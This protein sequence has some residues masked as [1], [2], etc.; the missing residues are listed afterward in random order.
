V[1]AA[2]NWDDSVGYL[3][4][5]RYHLVE[6]METNS[7]SCQNQTERVR[8]RIN[9]EWGRTSRVS[10]SA[11]V[12]PAGLT[13]FRVGSGKDPGYGEGVARWAWWVA[14]WAA[15]KQREGEWK[16]G[17]GWVGLGDQPGFGPLPNRS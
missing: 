15:R 3:K 11:W 1:L 12:N 14:S 4:G 7:I 10:D 9:Q 5:I 16:G 17:V 13:I 6:G 2:E 8:Y